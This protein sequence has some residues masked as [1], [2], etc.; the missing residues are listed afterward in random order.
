MTV[1]RGYSVAE[2]ERQKDDATKMYKAVKVLQQ[3]TPKETLRIENEEGVT[4]NEKEQVKIISN[5]FNSFFNQENA[6]LTH[7]HVK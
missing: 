6:Y 7:H 4:T 2:I 1:N 5:F 3:I